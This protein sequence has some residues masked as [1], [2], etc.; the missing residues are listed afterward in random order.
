[1]KPHWEW[2]GSRYLFLVSKNRGINTSF[3]RIQTSGVWC[4]E[5]LQKF[6]DGG[7]G[8]LRKVHGVTSQTAVFF[9]ATS[10]RTSDLSS[11]MC[12]S[13]DFFFSLEPDW[14]WKW[15]LNDINHIRHYTF[16][17][18][19]AK[20]Y[21]TQQSSTKLILNIHTTCSFNVTLRFLA[22]YLRPCLLNKIELQIPNSLVYSDCI[23][24]SRLPLRSNAIRQAVYV[25]CNIEVH[26]CNHYS[27]T[28]AISITYSE[29]FWAFGIQHA[30][31]MRH[32]VICGLYSSAVFFHVSHKRNDFRKTSYW[33]WNVCFRFLFALCPKHFSF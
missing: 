18:Q 25:W 33:T 30:R 26:S 23:G 1:V 5:V 29:S 12:H 14:N 20:P 13:E 28:K 3:W 6:E 17:M 2:S 15:Q 27:R 16:L 11:I 22:A 24:Q 9:I 31:R 10:A 7:G 32:I 21:V 8:V 19:C 4:C